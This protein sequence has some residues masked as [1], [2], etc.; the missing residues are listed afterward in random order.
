MGLTP[1]ERDERVLEIYDQLIEIEQRLI[2]TGLHILGQ[3]SSRACSVDMLRMVVSFERPELGAR[4]LP[5]LVAEGLGLSKE[6]CAS[7]SAPL[8]E[9]EVAERERIDVIVRSAI[10][11]F[12]ERGTVIGTE[13]L[14]REC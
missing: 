10:E 5:Q 11:V 1:D 14:W 4:A 9:A 13:Y 8:A 12:L 3:P 6:I 7:R 2:P